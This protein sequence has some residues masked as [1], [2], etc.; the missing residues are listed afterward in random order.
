MSEFDESNLECLI[1]E[2]DAW[3]VLPH[4]YDSVKSIRKLAEELGIADLL[5]ALKGEAFSCKY[6]PLWLVNT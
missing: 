1:S 6:I 5:P 4:L 3:E 2:E